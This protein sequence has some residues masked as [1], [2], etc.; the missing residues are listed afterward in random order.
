MGSATPPS[1]VDQKGV[2]RML[3]LFAAL[4][5]LGVVTLA[6]SVAL[7]LVV[8]VVAE[9]FFVVAYR[10]FSKSAKA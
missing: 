2:R 8:L 5:I 6:F 4:A 10:R 3:V 1:S 9:V 7:G